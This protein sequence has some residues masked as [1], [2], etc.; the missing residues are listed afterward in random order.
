[1]AGVAWTLLLLGAAPAA[2]ADTEPNGA[3][4][5]PEGPIAG[6]QD[7]EGT[8]DPGDRDDWYALHVDGVHQ[9][10]LTWTQLPPEG[11]SDVQG[12]VFPACVSVE[13]TNA[14]GSPIPPDF[15]SGRGASTFHVHV[16]QSGSQFCPSPTRYRFRVDPAEALVSGPGALPI[17]GTAE[18]NDSRSSAGGPLAPGAWYHSELETVNDQDWLRLYVRPGT[19]RVDVQA[20]VYGPQCWS[21][22]VK[23]RGARGAELSSSIGSREVV[24]HLTRRTRGGARLYVQIANG[25]STSPSSSGCVHAATVIQVA[26]EKAIMSAAEVREGCRDARTAA[27][28]SARRV[29]VRK[30]AIA[31]GKAR[32][33]ATGKLRRKLKLDRRALKRS[34]RLVSAYCSR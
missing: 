4:F 34:R 32:G 13:L 14:N 23:L 26:P 16:F 31:A 9:L 21:H 5:M 24:S 11:S 18:P 33:A 8:V 2:L 27:R 12:P 29:A 3:V 22:E 19:R 10:H 7:V 6:G 25:A 15:T 1:V 28:R 20:V 17:K 30:R